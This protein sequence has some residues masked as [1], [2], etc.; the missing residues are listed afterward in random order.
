M[1]SV[2]N[3][4]R[5]VTVTFFWIRLVSGQRQR[6]HLHFI[7]SS[8]VSSLTFF[9]VILL[10]PAR[11]AW[12]APKVNF[13]QFRTNQTIICRMCN[14][15]FNQQNTN[16]LTPRVVESSTGSDPQNPGICPKIAVSK[17]KTRRRREKNGAFWLL[18]RVKRSKFGPNSGIW[19]KSCD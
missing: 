8:F 12:L 17:G 7:F 9:R 13:S 6:F 14:K 2:C 16:S 1:R 4:Q 19:A 11:E 15:N 5:M 18:S 3:A 10:E